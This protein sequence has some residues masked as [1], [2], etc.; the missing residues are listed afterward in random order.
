MATLPNDMNV[1]YIAKIVG[2]VISTIMADNS[3]P[4]TSPKPSTP[5]TRRRDEYHGSTTSE[6]RPI[7]SPRK[8]RNSKMTPARKEYTVSKQ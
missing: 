2:I 5:Q 7:P 3:P 8:T 1:E 6:Y 4:S